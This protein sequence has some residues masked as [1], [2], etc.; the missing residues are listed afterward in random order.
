MEWMTQYQ[1]LLIF[2]GGIVL[3]VIGLAIKAKLADAISGKADAT[4]LRQ[5]GERVAG[6]EGRLMTIETGLRH[7][8]T[9]DDMHAI[10]VALTEQRGDMRA[11]TEKVDGLHD[12][13]EAQGRRIEMIDDHLTRRA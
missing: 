13:M 4:D 3:T 12:M 1:A 10:K 5:I 11:M 7:M 8:P 9:A 2:A 6:V